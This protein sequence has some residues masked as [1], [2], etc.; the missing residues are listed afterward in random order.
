MKYT[1]AVVVGAL[2]I[3]SPVSAQT[4][5]RCYDLGKTIYSDKPCLNGDEVRQIAPNGNPTAE[6]LARVRMKERA[7]EQ[8][9]IMAARAAKHDA[10]LAKAPKCVKGSAP[11][12]GCEP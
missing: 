6:Y 3:A 4:M 9:A 2:A 11:A 12:P 8:R 7:D 5:Y 1:I 10:E